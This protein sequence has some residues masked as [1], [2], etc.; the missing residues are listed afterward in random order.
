MTPAVT[1]QVEDA[2]GNLLATDN[3]SVTLTIATGP[4]GGNLGG[5]VTVAAVD[6]VATFSNLSLTT[7]G[8]YTLTASDA[9]L[10]VATSN[11]FTIA[12]AAADHLAVGQQPGN[13]TAGGTI[14][15]AV[16]I[17]VLDA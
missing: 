9:L 16:T 3:S 13:I 6:G 4:N 12:P 10:T 14:S 5:T 8:P 11:S 15:P 1:V 17:D 2:D 7:A